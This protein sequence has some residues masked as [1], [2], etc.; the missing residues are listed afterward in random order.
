MIEIKPDTVDR[1]LADI[2]MRDRF[3]PIHFP[4]SSEPYV[5]HDFHATTSPIVRMTGDGPHA[6]RILLRP[7]AGILIDQR[8]TRYAE[9]WSC[10][11]EGLGIELDLGMPYATTSEALTIYGQGTE[12][13]MHSHIVVRDVQFGSPDKRSLA[14]GGNE[15]LTPIDCWLRLSGVMRAHVINCNFTGN[16][17]YVVG[18][19]FDSSAGR[20]TD[21]DGSRYLA[22]SMK[23]AISSCNFG[24]GLSAGIQCAPDTWVEGL[25]IADNSFV[26]VATGISVLADGSH[27]GGT[28]ID[29]RDNHMAF[30][31]EAVRVEQGVVDIRGNY[32][33]PLPHWPFE[34]DSTHIRLGKAG[35]QKPVLVQLSRVRN[36][37]FGMAD[38]GNLPQSAVRIHA[39]SRRVSVGP[40]FVQGDPN[41]ITPLIADHGTVEQEGQQ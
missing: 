11:V 13:K 20:I 21:I 18:I 27:G 10:H 34:E 23:N 40:D 37:N 14:Q 26:D 33:I 29:I 8:E 25:T 4:A 22:R 36:N 16:W 15:R 41:L 28:L 17:R 2:S 19:L 32:T 30:R 31:R 9:G 12:N 7:G 6:S 5:L 24:P 38:P 1:Q 39:P 3:E 35:A